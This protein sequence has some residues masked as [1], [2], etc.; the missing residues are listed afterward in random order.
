MG[1][2]VRIAVDETNDASRKQKVKLKDM[3]SNVNE[4][5]REIEALRARSASQQFQPSPRRSLAP[6]S[7]PM[8]NAKPPQGLQF[9]GFR[10][11]PATTPTPAPAK[12]ES[13]F[14]AI[15]PHAIGAQQPVV[16]F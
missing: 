9:S 13:F 3:E 1:A 2:E 4:L 12:A 8:P 10:I 11:G 6:D 16:Q 15:D 14:S 7:Q 5:M